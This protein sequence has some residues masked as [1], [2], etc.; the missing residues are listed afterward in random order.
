MK[1]WIEKNSLWLS[2]FPVLL[3]M[4]MIFCFS[5]QDG[6]ESGALS[7]GI[8]AWLVERVVPGF[9]DMA[10]EQQET[11]RSTVGF[12]LRK[13]AHFSEYALLGFFLLLHVLQIGKRTVVKAPYLWAWLVGTLYA[14]S[15][16]IHQMFVP[17]RGPAVR[18]VCI[19]S[20]GVAA[21]VA[22]LCL[23]LQIHT[24]NSRKRKL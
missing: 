4:V 16:E 1:A 11:I 17:G 5:A 21:G 3:V 23:I 24:C 12:I 6:G 18:D 7:G 15:D 8:V 2:L 14:V 20:A 19:D 13:T 22:I 9:A 10:A